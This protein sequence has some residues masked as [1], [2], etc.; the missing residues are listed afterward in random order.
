[1]AIR[2]VDLQ[3]VVVKSLDVTRDTAAQ[4]QAA[5][6]QQAQTTEQANR[7]AHQAETVNEFDEAGAVLIRERQARGQQGEQ[8]EDEEQEQA[9]EEATVDGTSGKGAAPQVRLGRHIDL[10]A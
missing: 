6:T 3:Q 9:E 4:Q 7:R 8:R 10:Q 2:P 1:M 5:G